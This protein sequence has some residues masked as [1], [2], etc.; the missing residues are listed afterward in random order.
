MML[1]RMRT[2]SSRQHAIVARV[3]DLAQ[4]PDRT[5]SCL[6]LDG[7][8]LVADAQRASVN[9]EVVVVAASKAACDTEEGLLAR[10]LDA[11]GI[12]VV[13]A[14][15]NVFDAMSP[16]R[17]PSGILAIVSC[18]RTSIDDMCSP[19]D[20]L[21]LVVADVQD[22]GNVGA[23]VRTADAGGASGVVV[24]GRS[25]SPF[26]WKAVRGSMGSVLRRPVVAHETTLE[27][28]AG[29]KALELR[30]VAAVP[31][32]G[33]DPEAVNWHGRVGIVLGGEGGGLSAAEMSACDLRVSIPMTP[34]VES[35]NVSAAGA[36][37]LYV[38]RR[39]RAKT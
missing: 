7:A 10:S 26:S 3:R 9:F 21:V 16:V 31:R 36:I 23:L 1:G 24:C 17:S 4:R 19:P 11:S 33:M 28:I 39:A 13:E 8:H 6:L 27:A 18:P 30:M 2:I 14:T 22:P 35:L 32:D 20:A 34:H 25:A 38:A 37:L 12:D 29:L 5:G 15:D